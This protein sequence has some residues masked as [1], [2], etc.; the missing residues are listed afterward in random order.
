MRQIHEQ[1]WYLDAYGDVCRGKE[2]LATH[3]NGTPV[4][5]QAMAAALRKAGVTP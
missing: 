3:T 5:M 1:E 4:D 2:S